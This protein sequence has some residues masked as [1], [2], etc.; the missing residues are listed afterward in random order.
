MGA[1]YFLIFILHIFL[2]TWSTGWILKTI[3]TVSLEEDREKNGGRSFKETEGWMWRVGGKG[4]MKS[5]SCGLICPMWWQDPPLSLHFF[6]SPSFI[7]PVPKVSPLRLLWA[8]GGTH[9]GSLFSVT[10]EMMHTTQQSPAQHPPSNTHTHTTTT[11]HSH[12]T[13][14]QFPFP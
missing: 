12:T 6:N 2:W 11:K 4:R 1:W 5:A 8:E 7:L 14:T 10:H 9:G 13:L 3:S